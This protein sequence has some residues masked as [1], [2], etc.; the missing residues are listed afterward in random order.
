MKEQNEWINLEAKTDEF[1]LLVFDHS[2]ESQN[3]VRSYLEGLKFD[4]INMKKVALI[5]YN[6]FDTDW[7]RI[8]TEF[9][10]YNLHIYEIPLMKNAIVEKL[11]ALW[12]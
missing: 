7:K 10:K 3:R 11:C 1:Y 12:K 2:P 5:A 6:V 9:S 8:F 4:G